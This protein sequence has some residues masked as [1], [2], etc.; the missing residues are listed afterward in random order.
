MA[1]FS[2]CGAL[3]FRGKC[4]ICGVLNQNRKMQRDTAYFKSLPLDAPNP[5]QVGDKFY[6]SIATVSLDYEDFSANF[7][8]AATQYEVIADDKIEEIRPYREP[9]T[10]DAEPKVFCKLLEG[11]HEGRYFCTHKEAVESITDEHIRE[12][13]AEARKE[14]KRK[15]NLMEGELSDIERKGVN[16]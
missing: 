11:L 13:V 3:T 15:F 7:E 10:H 2:L 5:F 6:F 12:A 8:I 9:R 16:Q 14:V 4:Y 1:A